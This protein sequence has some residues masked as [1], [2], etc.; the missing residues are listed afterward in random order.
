MRI[1]LQLVDMMLPKCSKVMAVVEAGTCE[2]QLVC[3]RPT[4][5]QWSRCGAL[6]GETGGRAWPRWR[7]VRSG[8]TNL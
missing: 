5:V 6:D 7:M 4:S 1:K 2:P 3:G 8:H